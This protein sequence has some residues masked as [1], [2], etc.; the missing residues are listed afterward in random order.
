MSLTIGAPAPDFTLKNQFGEEVSLSQFRG[1]KPV[2]LV[3]YPLAF[4]GICTGELCE[5]RDNISVFKTNGVELL[6]ISVD[7]SPTLRVFA[8]KENYDFS[9]LS[10]RWPRGEVAS[11]YGVCLEDRGFGNR[12]TFVIDPEGRIKT[13]E[14][15][16]DGIGRDASE[17]LRRVKAA[18]YVA[19]H[20]GEVCPA[21]WSEG[22]QTLKPSLDL[23]G[24]I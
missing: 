19:A 16:D 2:V 8:E 17:T 12:G 24:K 23:V 10:D 18:Q 7:S 21:K 20:P 15:H 13:M 6:A 5:L 9:R 1:V 11:E 3:F 22:A 4:T 14:V